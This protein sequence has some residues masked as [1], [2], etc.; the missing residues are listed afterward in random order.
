MLRR[1]SRAKR[2]S[3]SM[4]CASPGGMLAA[5]TVLSRAP[6]DL[7]ANATDAARSCPT[8]PRC[9]RAKRAST[10]MVCASSREMHATPT[11]WSRAPHDSVVSA[12]DKSASRAFFS[13]SPRELDRS[14][15]KLERSPPEVERFSFLP[16]ARRRCLAA[17]RVLISSTRPY[18][19][20]RSISV[21]KCST[22]VIESRRMGNAALRWVAQVF[23]LMP[24]R[25]A[26]LALFRPSKNSSAMISRCVCDMS[27]R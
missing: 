13:A 12:T 21:E 19:S 2:A 4:L 14:R 7:V 27:F 25:A 20:G 6:H 15:S 26:M 24:R 9:S 22:V 17:S 3:A 23:T 1:C 8:L 11:V 18:Q 16:D 10:S 5:P